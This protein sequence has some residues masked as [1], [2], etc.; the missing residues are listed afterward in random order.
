MARAD[1]FTPIGKTPE[2]YKDFLIN[3]DK[4]PS[5]DQLSVVVNE[6]AIKQRIRNLVLTVNGERFY[7][8]EIGSRINALLFE[9]MGATTED[10]IITE[11]TRTIRTQEPAVQDLDVRVNGM[12]ELNGYVVTV[13]FTMLNIPGNIKLDLLL[14]RVR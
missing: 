3:F 11:V 5:T 12:E 6:D 2:L 13:T 9:P 10:G 4:S 8:S 1:R 14:Q 7:H